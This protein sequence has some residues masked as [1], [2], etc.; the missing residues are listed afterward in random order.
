MIYLHGEH[1]T[2]QASDKISRAFKYPLILF[3]ISKGK[4]YSNLG[5]IVYI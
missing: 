4:K 5:K 3:S 1:Y 2:M